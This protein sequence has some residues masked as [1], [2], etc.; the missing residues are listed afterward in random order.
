MGFAFQVQ[1]RNRIME[2]DGCLWY[3]THA[4]FV[5]MA[6]AVQVWIVIPVQAI[7]SCSTGW[8]KVETAAKK[9]CFFLSVVQSALDE[10]R[11][12]TVAQIE[13]KP[14]NDFCQHHYG[15]VKMQSWATKAQTE[16]VFTAVRRSSQQTTTLLLF[17]SSLLPRAS[18]NKRYVAKIMST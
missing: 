13:R 9:S 16:L 12:Y 11:S 8:P 14:Y 4:L 18:S 6:F 3:D 7:I 1:G 10:N 5:C 2:R 15:L 17:K